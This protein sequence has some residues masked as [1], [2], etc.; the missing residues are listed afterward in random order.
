MTDEIDEIQDVWDEYQ[1]IFSESDSPAEQAEAVDT[2]LRVV[3]E[4]EEQGLSESHVDAYLKRVA[5]TSDLYTVTSIRGR[6]EEL[7][8]EVRDAEEGTPPLDRFLEQGLRKVIVTRVTDHHVDT[9]YQWHLEGPED[10]VIFTTEGNAHW[11]WATFR[12]HYFDETGIDLDTP[13]REHREGHTWRDFL[14]ERIEENRIDKKVEG[15]RTEAVNELRE[16]VEA[17]PAF[18]SHKAASMRR[19]PYLEHEDA[20]EILIPLGAITNICRQ[21]DIELRALQ[22]ELDARNLTVGGSKR[23]RED[24]HEEGQRASYW[25]LNTTVGTPTKFEVDIDD[26]FDPSMLNSEGSESDEETGQW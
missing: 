12:E 15:P 16:F 23:V 26:E 4:A 25:R 13:R 17:G 1:P 3:A 19:R 9:S 11:N 18:G 2:F 14:V 20:D 24:R 8:D 22:E 6:L 7:R 5:N 10:P 21:M